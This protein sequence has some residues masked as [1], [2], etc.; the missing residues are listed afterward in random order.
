MFIL[1]DLLRALNRLKTKF[2]I[3]AVTGPR[4]SGKTTLLRHL[5]PDYTYVTL[6]S[7]DIRERAL[8]DPLGFLNTYADRVILDEVQQAP[9]LFSYLQEKV[10]TDRVMGQYVLSGSQ[11]FQLLENITQSLAG[12]V[13]MF[14]LFPFT[15][16]E[17]SAVGKCPL[18]WEDMAFQGSYPPVYDRE[19]APTDFYLNYVETYL[20]RDVRQLINIR[21]VRP[22]RLFLK[23]CA[24][25]IGQMLNIQKLANDIGISHATAQAWL[26]VLETSY[27]LFRLPPYYRNFNK[28]LVKT[29]RLY[30]YD[31]GLACY[32]LEMTR[33]VDLETYYQRGAIFE[34]LLIAELHKNQYHNYG[35]PDFYFWRDNNGLEVDLIFEEAGILKFAEIKSGKTTNNTFYANL[36]KL[37]K[38]A[39]DA[40]AKRFLLYG[41][42]DSFQ[43]LGT[44]VLGWQAVQ[45]MM[46]H[47]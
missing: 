36:L 20:E 23:Y 32:L 35:K 4:Q 19:I 34:N 24:G 15:F 28:R 2:P 45:R 43:H 40:A 9:Q 7:P 12:R 10:D 17:L 39:D 37:D 14:K 18:R 3:L 25:H 5:F 41:G 47:S 22:F 44:Q 13:A 11:N 27:I 46:E 8:T 6:E 21:D 33:V 42:S 38:A 30:F 1:R 16:Q 26:N 31:T 29:P